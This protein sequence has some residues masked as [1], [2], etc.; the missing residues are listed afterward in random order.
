MYS[1]IFFDK[2]TDKRT[3]ENRIISKADIHY[4]LWVFQKENLRPKQP[5]SD[6]CYQKE[7]RLML[8]LLSEKVPGKSLNV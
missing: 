4:H 1:F 7:E 3:T 8:E 2:S 6:R 5:G